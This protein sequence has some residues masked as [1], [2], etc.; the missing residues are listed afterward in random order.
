MCTHKSSTTQCNI[1]HTTATMQHRV[2]Q[3]TETVAQHDQVAKPAIAWQP[4]EKNICE[5]NMP[6]KTFQRHAFMQDERD[7]WQAVH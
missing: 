7:H 4:R 6:Q 2:A 5:C 1:P 3:I